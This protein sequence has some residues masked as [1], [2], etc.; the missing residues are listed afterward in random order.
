MKYTDLV[1]GSADR[2]KVVSSYCDLHGNDVD[3]ITYSGKYDDLE[4]ERVKSIEVESS[5]SGMRLN[6][7]STSGRFGMRYG[8]LQ[9]DNIARGFSR[10][11]INTSYTGVDL[12]FA[13]DASFV[14]DAQNNYCNIR[15]HGLKITEDIQKAGSTTLKASKGSGGGQVMARMN[16]GEL[17][18]Q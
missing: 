13:E 16:Y 9:V 7:L 3:E 15:H 1:M 14:I 11:D 18:I 12:D 6:G 2:L 4:F 8:D 10:L 17:N 5:Y